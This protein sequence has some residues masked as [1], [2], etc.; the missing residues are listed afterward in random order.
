MYKLCN[1]THIKKMLFEKRNMANIFTSIWFW[2]NLLKEKKVVSNKKWHRHF[3]SNQKNIILVFC[4]YGV[5]QFSWFYF[6]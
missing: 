2:K 6:S 3:V 4:C 5:Y 1:H